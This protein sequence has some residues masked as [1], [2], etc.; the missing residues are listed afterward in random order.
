MKK[1]EAEDPI[2]IYRKELIAGK[3]A[4][5][6]ELDA[7][8]EEAMK[9][10][11]DAEAFAEASPNPDKS[12]LFEDIYVEPTPVEYRGYALERESEGR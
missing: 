1:W 7:V 2:G 12:T 4:T 9:I 6:K 8:D 11:D 3:I 5:A 10:V